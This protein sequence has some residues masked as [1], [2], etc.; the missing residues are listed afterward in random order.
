M[1]EAILVV[2]TKPVAGREDDF[3]DWYT[4]IHTRDALRFRGAIAQQRFRL[5]AG[6]VQDFEGGAYH[7]P[8]LALYEVFDAHR[9]A[10]EHVD[11][12]LTPKMVCE[13]SID[14]S[15]MDDFHY[16]PLQF[17]DRSPR[18]LGSCSAVLEQ[19]MPAQGRERQFRDWY[20][21]E[22]L[23]QRF[24]DERIASAAFLQ[25]D[26]H[27]QIFT[28]LPEQDYVGIWRLAD[29]GARDLW[30][31]E[32]LANCPLVDAR[33]SVVTCWD[34]L[35]PRLTEDDVLHPTP[36][37][38]AAELRAHARIAAQ[39]SAQTQRGMLPDR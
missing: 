25:F 13:D 2:L 32:T 23:P 10:R 26:P 29:D 15:R 1:I 31:S 37:G 30:R 9:F 12:G 18:T 35:T 16:Y 14:V 19:I 17:R 3:N 33:R 28:H 38:L 4:N 22:Y 36:E 8:Y 39:G 6:Q 7:S 24:R 20:N 34:I 11:W 5:S 27:G 21:D